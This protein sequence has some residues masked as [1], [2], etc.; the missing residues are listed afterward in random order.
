ML[1]APPAA[2]GL[3]EPAQAQAHAA[4]KK[5]QIGRCM[6]ERAKCRESVRGVKCLTVWVATC[7]W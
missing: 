6:M 1:L 5:P 2:V 3:G 4:S 7:R